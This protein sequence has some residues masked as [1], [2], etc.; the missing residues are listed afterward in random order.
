MTAGWSGEY[1]TRLPAAS[2]D[3]IRQLLQRSY[4]GVTEQV[5]ERYLQSIDGILTAHAVAV[6]NG[7]DRDISRSRAI[8]ANKAA[9]DLLKI[10]ADEQPDFDALTGLSQED[11]ATLIRILTALRGHTR[12][13]V[14]EYAKPGRP[15]NNARMI[16]SAIFQ[17]HATLIG[18]EPSKANGGTFH[19]IIEE[20]NSGAKL[21]IPA[22]RRME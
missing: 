2:R 19:H 20:I 15:P 7:R 16:L 11:A 6:A 12:W 18:E 22:P 14:D 10:A 9:K 4:K 3:K 13:L 17:M 8:K 5:A 21:K 1:S